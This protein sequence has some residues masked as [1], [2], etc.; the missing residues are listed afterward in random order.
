MGQSVNQ[1]RGSGCVIPVRPWVCGTLTSKNTLFRTW[2]AIAL[3]TACCEP[4]SDFKPR[5]LE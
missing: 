5:T 1:M 2:L 3:E 4:Y